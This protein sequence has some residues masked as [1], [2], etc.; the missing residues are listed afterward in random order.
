M[1]WRPCMLVWVRGCRVR[2]GVLCSSVSQ[3]RRGRQRMAHVDLVRSCLGDPP[4]GERGIINVV[5]QGGTPDH[6][7]AGAQLR[8]SWRASHIAK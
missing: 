4:W 6:S 8:S 3:G 2:A 7:A 5:I 1:F